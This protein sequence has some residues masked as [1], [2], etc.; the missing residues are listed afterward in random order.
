MDNT[1]QNNTLSDK[2]IRGEYQNKM[3]TGVCIT[4]AEKAS[5][6]NIRSN[7]IEHNRINGG[8]AGSYNDGLYDMGMYTLAF[9]N[10]Y[11]GDGTG[12]KCEVEHK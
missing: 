4:H 5:A 1:I 10:A 12:F 7:V 2:D 6:A 3:K 9:C 11:G 8:D